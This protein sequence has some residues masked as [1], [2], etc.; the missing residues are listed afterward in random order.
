MILPTKPEPIADAPDLVKWRELFSNYDLLIELHKQQVEKYGQMKVAYHQELLKKYRWKGRVMP[1]HAKGVEYKP[2]ELQ[3]VE[4]ACEH[5]PAGLCVIP[6]VHICGT[7]FGI[8]R[9]TCCV[10]DQTLVNTS[11]RGWMTERKLRDLKKARE[12]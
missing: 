6:R 7:T 11:Q 2:E 1:G 9:A 5:S 10:C 12:E 3:V 4:H 8:H